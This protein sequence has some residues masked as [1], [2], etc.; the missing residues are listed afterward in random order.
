[1][2]GPAV[3]GSKAGLLYCRRNTTTA[4]IV[5]GKENGTRA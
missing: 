3:G 2:L 5:I 4:R 1:M